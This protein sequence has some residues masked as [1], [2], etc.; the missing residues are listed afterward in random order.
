[1]NALR[2]NEAGNNFKTFVAVGRNERT[3]AQWSRSWQLD[4]STSCERL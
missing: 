4:F 3:R 1:M 2:F